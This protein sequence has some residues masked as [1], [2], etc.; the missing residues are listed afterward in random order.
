MKKKEQ[1]RI[2][3]TFSSGLVGPGIVTWSGVEL[4]KELE[5]SASPVVYSV[6]RVTEED[7]SWSTLK[8]LRANPNAS[9]PVVHRCSMA[10]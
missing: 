9:N 1:T 10:P 7:M 5:H 8:L 3:Q 6:P 2:D 4:K